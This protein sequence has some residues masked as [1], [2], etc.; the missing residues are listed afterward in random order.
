[1]IPHSPVLV[2]RGK[3]NFA[4][5]EVATSDSSSPWQGISRRPPPAF[6]V[7]YIH[8]SSL[9]SK[10]NLRS[11]LPHPLIPLCTPTKNPPKCVVF[12]LYEL[13]QELQRQNSFLN[14]PNF[15]SS[16]GIAGFDSWVGKLL[17]RRKWQPTPVLLPGKFR[18][19][20]IL[21]GYSPWGRKESDMTEQLHWSMRRWLMVVMKV[22]IPDLTRCGRQCFEIIS[23]IP[24][25]P[26]CIILDNAFPLRMGETWNLFLISRIW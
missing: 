25:P 7:I 14:N 20:R 8:M 16:C 11:S 2:A 17:W 24:A 19:W 10:I 21:V 18:G 6:G 12:Q 5:M 1:M 9:S 26:V 23:K 4:L 13:W 3:R 15:A 22:A